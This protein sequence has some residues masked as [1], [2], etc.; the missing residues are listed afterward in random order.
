M[1]VIDFGAVAEALCAQV[2]SVLP[3]LN[4]YPY[5]PDNPICPAFIVAT[6]DADIAGSFGTNDVVTYETYVL[7]DRS[8]SERAAQALLWDLIRG[9]GSKSVRSAIIAGRATRLGGTVSGVMPIKLQ[10]PR[11]FLFGK[12]WRYGAKLDIKVT[13]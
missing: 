7:V 5:E 12:I 2:H 13:A 3:A 11:Q 1:A 9:D 6:F 8:G 10:G 4:C